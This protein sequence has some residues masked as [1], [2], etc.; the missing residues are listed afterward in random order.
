MLS[1]R[2]GWIEVTQDCR[3]AQCQ[4]RNLAMEIQ[5]TFVMRLRENEVIVGCC[6]IGAVR[7]GKPRARWVTCVKES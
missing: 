2:I 5:L 3:C 1:R 6:E 4:W 7:T